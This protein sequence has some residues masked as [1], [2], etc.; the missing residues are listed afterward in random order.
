MELCLALRVGAER[1]EGRP[2]RA[3]DRLK[4]HQRGPVPA[5]RQNPCALARQSER[6]GASEAA[7]ASNDQRGPAAE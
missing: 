5:R 6:H 2:A 7:R 4:L 1:E 3:R